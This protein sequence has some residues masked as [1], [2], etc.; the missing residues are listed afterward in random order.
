[1]PPQAPDPDQQPAGP[2]PGPIPRQNPSDERGPVDHGPEAYPPT[3]A[4]EESW[5]QHFRQPAPL[6]EEAAQHP[7]HP[8]YPPHP[9]AEE[10]P[11]ADEY[12]EDPMLPPRKALAPHRQRPD[13]PAPPYQQQGLGGGPGAQAGPAGGGYPPGSMY[14]QQARRRR[15]GTARHTE[16]TPEAAAPLDPRVA[17][18]RGQHWQKS[19]SRRDALIMGFL[20]MCVI[21]VL[22][23]AFLP[24][25]IIGQKRVEEPVPEYQVGQGAGGDLDPN[26]SSA[27]LLARDRLPG[28]VGAVTDVDLTEKSPDELTPEERAALVERYLAEDAVAERRAAERRAALEA[29]GTGA[30]PGA[31]TTPSGPRSEAEIEAEINQKILDRA[32]AT[33]P[34]IPAPPGVPVIPPTG[35]AGVPEYTPAPR[36]APPAP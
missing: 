25:S 14:P 30:T 6:P 7:P 18:E 13:R 1:M 2:R 35:G 19:R 4:P 3:E 26:I 20:G 34:A 9:S 5:G 15:R 32:R 31:G 28:G 17:M 22:V 12:L 11:V 8:H 29:A 16:I 36:P 10:L 21:A 23:V 24:D 33:A 27:E